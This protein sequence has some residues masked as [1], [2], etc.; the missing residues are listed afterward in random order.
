MKT[1]PTLLGQHIKDTSCK[2]KHLKYFK[3]HI[4]NTNSLL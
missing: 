4:E 2:L 1:S 3:K